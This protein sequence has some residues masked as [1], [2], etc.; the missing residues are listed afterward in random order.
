MKLICPYTDRFS[1]PAESSNPRFFIKD[2]P[3]SAVCMVVIAADPD[4]EKYHWVVYNIPVTEVIEENFR[5]GI[6][7]VN[8]F[9]RHSYVPPQSDDED[10]RLI[11]TVFALDVVLNIGGGKG[12]NDILR[13]IK[14][15]ICEY[16]IAECRFASVSADNN[17]ILE[18]ADLSVG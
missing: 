5:K 15:H 7:A 9:G 2:I 18:D 8:D 4:A 1:V 10:S 6:N 12:G 13:A 14:G 3:P 17:S 11:F 16:A